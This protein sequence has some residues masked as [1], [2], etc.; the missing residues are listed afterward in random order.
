MFHSN[1]FRNATAAVGAVFVS[2]LLVGASV[3]PVQVGPVAIAATV[4]AVSG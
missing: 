4:P 3:G 2:L 1:L